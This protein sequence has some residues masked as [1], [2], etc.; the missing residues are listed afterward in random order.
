MKSSE[1]RRSLL[2]RLGLPIAMVQVLASVAVAWIAILVVD[3]FNQSRVEDV[4]S[5]HTKLLET[6][7][8]SDPSEENMI[9]SQW[10]AASPDI[11]LT[12]IDAS[13]QVRWDSD[14]NPADMENHGDRPEVLGAV[15]SGQAV[16]TRFSDT[17][18]E[19]MTYVARQFVT[20]GE[21]SVIRASMRSDLARA[22][23]MPIIWSILLVLT[24]LLVVTLGAVAIVSRHLD[25]H[26][27]RL[28]EGAKRL[29]AGDFDFRSELRLPAALRPLGLSLDRIAEDQGERIHQLSVQQSEM[30]GIL[31]ALRTGVI[32]MGLDGHVISMNPAASRILLLDQFKVQGQPLDQLG[33]D[34]RLINFARSVAESGGHGTSEMSLDSLDGRQVVVQSEPIHDDDDQQVGTVLVLDDVTRMRR[35]EAMRTD[36]S[37][38]VSHE[39]RTPIT[40]IQGYAELLFD[41]RDDSKRRRY[42][43]VVVSNA[44][45]LSAIIEDLLA[46]SRLEDPEGSHLPERETLAVHELLDEVAV[47]CSD[48]AADREIVLKVKC[49][50]PLT[51]HGSR[52][53]LEQAVS[54][55]VV[56][57]IRYG[58]P[59]S[60]VRLS[61][62]LVESKLH[63]T[64]AD[65]G[66]GID[67][68]SHRRLFERFF[69]IDRGRSREVGGTGLGL[70]IVKHIAQ[71]HGGSVDVESAPGEG[72]IFTVA[73]PILS[74]HNLNTLPI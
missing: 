31:F 12:L 60:T 34:R 18:G 53:L 40:A 15:S 68:N 47:A 25:Q 48:E 7:I 39:L 56:N 29:A 54:N 70:A 73:L 10:Q 13:G 50:E 9:L 36:F 24:A 55:L 61:A 21:S 42:I 3:D 27:R 46:L 44:T 64:V 45:R 11:R 41:E 6:L 71:A 37:S 52:Q 4:L 43:E 30:Q 17:I 23:I 67:E 57:A 1:S 51:C 2:W 62:K 74:E 8:E 38:N 16:Q 22:Q 65:E 69:R 26:V 59:S 72:S 14:S 20:N 19:S 32:A 28:S 35:L 49:D 66:P 58:P 63:I 5:R 33:I